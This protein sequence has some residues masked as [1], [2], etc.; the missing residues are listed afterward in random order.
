MSILRRQ[1][2]SDQLEKKPDSSD[3]K[4]HKEEKQKQ[5]QN[6]KKD[7]QKQAEEQNAKKDHQK[8]IWSCID[9]CF[10]LIGCGLTMGCLLLFLYQFV[11]VSFTQYIKEA[12]IGPLPDPPGLKLKKEG[13][14]ANHPV[15]LIP[16]SVSG[17]LEL[18]EG[19]ECAH[20]LFR[21]RI[22]GGTFGQLH[23]RFLV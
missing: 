18:W 4:K 23:M 1:K 8:Q 11:P 20:S 22:W 21:K 9:R 12:I 6:P 14:T 10:W 19:N 7:H 2:K 5:Q 3:K 15:V 16:G 13:L 17:G